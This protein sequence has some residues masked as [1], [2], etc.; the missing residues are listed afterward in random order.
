MEPILVGKHRIFS[1]DDC[2]RVLLTGYFVEPNVLKDWLRLSDVYLHQKITPEARRLK[3]SQ[4]VLDIALCLAAS[5]R[6]IFKFDGTSTTLSKQYYY[7]GLLTQVR[8]FHAAS[9][10]RKEKRRAALYHV[11]EYRYNHNE[12]VSDGGAI[13][14]MNT[15]YKT[16]KLHQ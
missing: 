1:G 5:L 9:S 11:K 2:D 14:M 3:L 8:A 10:K 12:A 15:E 6:Q 16:T 4:T 13:R 7:I